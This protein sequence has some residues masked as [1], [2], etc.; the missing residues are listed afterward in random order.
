[1]YV[2][3]IFVIYCKYS[4]NH[5]TVITLSLIIG[6]KCS[7]S[8]NDLQLRTFYHLDS[9][10]SSGLSIVD[11]I[12]TRGSPGWH[13]TWQV[14]CLFLLGQ[15][16]QSFLCPFAYRRSDQTLCMYFLRSTS[17]TQSSSTLPHIC[18]PASTPT[19]PWH[20]LR[21]RP[22]WRLHGPV[23]HHTPPQPPSST[24]VGLTL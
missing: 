20:D 9:K 18:P 12:D 14:L 3:T 15:G 6:T 8:L 22:L 21:R 11:V 4:R 7:N 19:W 2:V 23:R 16:R 24:Q 17:L 1:M 13:T 5:D 10:L